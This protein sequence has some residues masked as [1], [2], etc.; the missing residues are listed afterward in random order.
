MHSLSSELIDFELLPK[1]IAVI[2]DG[3]GRWAKARGKP[4]LFGHHAGVEA[5]R[6]IVANAN[7]LGIRALTLFAFSRENW[8]RPEEEVHLLMALFATVLTREVRKLHKN[9][10][11]FKVMGD[12][13]RFSSSLQDK[14]RQAE[15][16]TAHNT[17][18]VLNVA[19]NY[20]GQWDIFQAVQK[21]AFDVEAGKLKAADLS[22]E[23]ISRNLLSA[24]LPEVDLLIR[25]SGECRI[26][27]F[28]LWQIA[29]AEI[30]FTEQFW[31]DFDGQ[32]LSEAI[33][34][35]IQRERRFGCTSEQIQAMLHVT[36]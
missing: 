8:A 34:W 30:Y 9:G 27:N 22:S 14:I 26:S 20:G 31:P 3:N 32:S 6:K 11:K 12:I 18:I 17:G 19:A 24:D 2:M 28:M 15:Q 25:T 29:Y 35:Y 13:S 1:H 7:K 36:K 5:V 23:V 21:V 16:L 10:V 33:A 4:R